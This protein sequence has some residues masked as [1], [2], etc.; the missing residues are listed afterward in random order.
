MPEFYSN[1][2]FASRAHH[3][4]HAL[5]VPHRFRTM[6]HFVPS[7]DSRPTAPI[8]L[9]GPKVSR[10]VDINLRFQT[11][12]IRVQPQSYGKLCHSH[13][14]SSFLMGF[15]VPSIHVRHAQSL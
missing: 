3:D 10:G 9:S 13:S 6:R 1:I 14:Y 7:G 4:M 15:A 2:S 11:N 8:L 12:Y 5:R